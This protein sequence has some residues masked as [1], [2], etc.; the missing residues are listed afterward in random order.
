MECGVYSTV[1][2]IPLT[3]KRVSNI[4]FF[5]FQ[6]LNIKSAQIS[7]H[8]IGYKKMK[9][10]N[11]EYRGK[12]YVTDV[13]SFACMDLKDWPAIKMSKKESVDFGDIFIC[14]P[15]I[16]RQAKEQKISINKEMTE[17]LIHGTLHLLGY[18]HIETVDAK[19]MLPLQEKFLSQVLK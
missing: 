5:V 6:S 7:V 11:S 9:T 13:L 16:E 18:D 19:K 1:K 10:M 15:Q 2:R 3:K 14:V 4:V 12:N 17:M 8:F